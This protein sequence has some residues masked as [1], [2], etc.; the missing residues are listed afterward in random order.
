MKFTITVNR[1]GNTFTIELENSN[2]KIARE[3]FA[4]LCNRMPANEGFSL[5]LSQRINTVRAIA[6]SEGA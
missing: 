6:F 2:E 1:Y 3:V 5:Q 4:D